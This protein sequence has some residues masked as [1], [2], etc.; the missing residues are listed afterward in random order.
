MPTRERKDRLQKIIAWRKSFRSTR[1]LY[2]MLVI[3]LVFLIVFHYL[4][5]YGVQIAFRDFKVTKGILGSDW[6]G[7]KYI[8]KLLRTPILLKLIMNTVKVN[9]YSLL[10]GFPAPIILALALNYM[11]SRRYMKC[12]QTVSFMPHFISAIVIVGIMKQMFNTSYGVVNQVIE[13]L[14]FSKIDFMGLPQYFY[15]MYVGSGI[16]QQVGWNA[17]IYIAALS[18]VDPS[19]HESAILDGA[20]KLKRMWYIDLPT[21]RPTI[22][23]L[24]IMSFGSFF[25]TGF[26]KIFVM[27][28]DLNLSVS[29]TLDTYVY[30]LGI[31][32]ASYSFAAAVGLFQSLVGFVLLICVNAVCRRLND[33]SLF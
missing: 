6:V 12:V 25:H 14:G 21:I 5:M 33:T 27:Q 7:L 26:E 17:I 32:Q 20:S 8:M 4:P 9:V 13:A 3:P 30:K 15:Q 2:A 24:L 18:A 10:F 19:L 23:I 1:Q 16:W 22:V 29:E 28:T 31:Q 11:S